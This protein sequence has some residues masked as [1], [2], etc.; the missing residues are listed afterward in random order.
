MSTMRIT[1]LMLSQQV[2]ANINQQQNA[3][4]TTEQELSSGK[5]INQPSDDPY[6][7]S[8]AVSLN[9]QLAK[10]SDYQGNVT[11]GTAW[12]AAGLSAMSSITQQVQ[13]AQE[14]VT[15]AA[16]GS[17]SPTD[18]KATGAEIDQ[19]I[20]GIKSDANAQYN[21]QYIFSGTSTSTAP[22]V[23]SATDDS[24]HG[25]T[26]SVTREVSAGSFVT[27]NS[28]LSQVL[29]GAGG[30]S[31]LLSQLRSISTALDS[32]QSPPSSALTDLSA[33][34]DSLGQQ[35]T[36]LGAA[37]D[38]LTLAGTRL[39]SLQTSTTSSLSDD[40]DANIAAT[41]TTFSNQQAAFT[42]ALKAG[43]NIVQSSLMDFLSSS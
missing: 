11:D 21:G 3:I 12:T 8:L 14:L 18:L 28:Q 7:A 2:L 38:R 13:R 42:A 17:E 29:N 25:D 40:Q 34:L 39:T 26:G 16:N 5:R 36:S 31:G 19:L 15:A 10:L 9:G 23:D 32:G 24:Y 35:T 33:S 37:S 6:G 27:V 1:N 22:Y 41:Y 30:S 20:S 43:A 4:D